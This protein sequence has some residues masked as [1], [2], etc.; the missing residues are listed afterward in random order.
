MVTVIPVSSASLD[1]VVLTFDIEM[2]WMKDLPTCDG[3]FPEQNT[4]CE[5]LLTELPEYKMTFR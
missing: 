1:G 3:L 5:Q 2:D 4:S